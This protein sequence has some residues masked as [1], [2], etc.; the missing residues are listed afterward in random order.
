MSQNK[1]L[2]YLFEETRQLTIS[3]E[4]VSGSITMFYA[5][6]NGAKVIVD[7]GLKKRSWSGKIPNVQVRIKVRV[8]GID[9]A[10]FKFGIDLPGTTEDQNILLKLQDGYNET[11]IIL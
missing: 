7:D 9:N 5:F 11:E 1:V 3:L 4:P 10:A 8:V 2:D 6:I